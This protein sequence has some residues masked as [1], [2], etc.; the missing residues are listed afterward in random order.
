MYYDPL[1]GVCTWLVTVNAK[2]VSGSI[3]GT[4]RRE[5]RKIGLYG[6]QY[7]AHR[8]IWFWMTREWPKNNIDHINGSKDDNRWANLRDVETV[9]NLQNQRRARSNN[10]FGVLGVRPHHNKFVSRIRHEGKE[11]HLGSFDTAEK[12]HIAYVTAK[13]QIH[14]GNTL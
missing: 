14:A 9:T 10:L 1:T 13:R 6:K 3:A 8:L 4:V 5:Y 2:A 7:Q 12:A 11:I